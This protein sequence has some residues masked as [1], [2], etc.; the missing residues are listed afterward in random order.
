[1][2]PQVRHHLGGGVDAAGGNDI[3]GENRAR[4]RLAPVGVCAA[5]GVAEPAAGG[6]W[7]VDRYQ[8]ARTVANIRKI[9][10]PLRFSGHG[11]RVRRA[12][13]KP[14]ALIAEKEKGSVLLHGTAYSSAILG[15]REGRAS[16]AGLIVQRRVRVD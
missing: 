13:A 8:R 11:V 16:H 3:V 7:I 15:L 10:Y 14:E 6:Q 12:L 1:M 5:G 9:A 2:R 4:N